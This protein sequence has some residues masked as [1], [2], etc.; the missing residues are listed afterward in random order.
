MEAHMRKYEASG[1]TAA[2]YCDKQKLSQA[3]FYYWRKKPLPKPGEIA[4]SYGSQYS[5]LV[6]ELFEMVKHCPH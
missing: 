6:T 4:Q 5:G 1:Q 3:T 2:T